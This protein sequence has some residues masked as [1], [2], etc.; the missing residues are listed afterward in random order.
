MYSNINTRPKST[1]IVFSST[2]V[3]A[4]MLVSCASTTV[5]AKRTARI[6]RQAPPRRG[7]RDQ[8]EPDPRGT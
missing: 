2:G 8:A 7:P 5:D 3:Y 6:R 1:V 4:L